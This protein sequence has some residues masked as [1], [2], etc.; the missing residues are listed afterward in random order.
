MRLRHKKILNLAKGYRLR[1]KNVFTV[2]INRVQYALRQAYVGRKLRKRDAR[3]TWIIQVGAATRLHGLN[4]ST[5]MHCAPMSGIALDR[6]VL[7]ELAQ[8]EP[9]SFKAVVETVKTTGAAQW[10]AKRQQE[11][12]NNRDKTKRYVDIRLGKI[13]PQFTFR[14]V[15]QKARVQSIDAV[16]AARK[17]RLAEEADAARRA[18][19]RRVIDSPVIGTPWPDSNSQ[20]STDGSVPADPRR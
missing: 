18:F 6:K 11:K 9:Y 16:V 7:A 5:F 15:E 13:K 14:D 2:A 17:K 19:V 4:Y 8:S 3:R 12:E 10:L 20:T 1:G